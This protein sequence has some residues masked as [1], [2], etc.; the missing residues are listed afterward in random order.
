MRDR[1][2]F[3]PGCRAPS[4]MAFLL[5]SALLSRAAS[6]QVEL[7]L[8]VSASVAEAP[9]TLTVTAETPLEEPI[10]AYSWSGL[11]V[12]PRCKAKDC[13]LDLPVASC[14]RVE[15]TVTDRFGE[16]TSRSRQVCALEE[17][18]RPPEA[19]I[20]LEGSDPVV[21]TAGVKAGTATITVIQLFVDDILVDGIQ[22]EIPRDGCHVV[23]LMVADAEGRIGVDQRVVCDRRD[24][25][26]IWVGAT[27]SFCVRSDEPFT[28]CSEA[29][30]PFGEEVSPI[31]GDEI[32][33]GECV[34]LPRPEGLTRYVVRGDTDEARIH[35]AIFGCTAPDK[36][37]PVL[38]FARIGSLYSARKGETGQFTVFIDGGQPP[39]SVTGVL[40]D[41]STSERET[42]SSEDRVVGLPIPISLSADD[43]TLEVTV[44]DSRDQ[45][46]SATAT[47]ELMNPSMSS[48][49]PNG[50][51]QDAGFSCAASRGEG[52]IFTLLLPLAAL[53]L[54]RRRR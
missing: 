17:G 51:S 43:S 34:E 5:A 13:T 10:L 19:S 42:V 48:P 31:S 4:V 21:V 44:T 40:R 23:D 8:V 20:E 25:A 3:S 14:R 41:D 52:A 46:A 15:V 7:D 38:M 36:G 47:I 12:A 29:D 53:L 27:P 9:V 45:R 50:V 24:E 35:G 30:A 32:P 22:A 26:S 39:F 28:V 2:S 1:H 49:P 16:E 54:R 6:A 33:L 18:A 11:G 37:R